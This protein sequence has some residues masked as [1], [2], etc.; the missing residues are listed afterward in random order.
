MSEPKA[1]LITGSTD[2][3]G[4]L[5]ARKL[6]ALGTTVLVHGRSRER[7]DQLVSQIRA[8]GGNAVFYQ[9]DLASLAQVRAL[10]DAVRRDHTRL[11]VLINNAGIGTG[12]RGAARQTSA[13]GYESRFAVNYLSGFLLTRLLLPLILRSAPARIVNV[14]SA[15]QYPL[16]F[17]NLMLT[18]A[19]SGMRAYAQSKLAQV[20]F[21][22]GLA[23]ELEGTG[24]TVN[25]LHPAT[26]MNTT[27]VHE[28]GVT[29]VSTVEEGAQ[30]VLRLAVAADLQNQTGAYF[31]GQRPGRAQAQAYDPQAQR[32]LHELSIEM[33][34]LVSP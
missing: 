14:A 4:R 24:V 27:M 8:D 2:G 15:G 6:A 32:R 16:D 30:A 17:D 11:D 34:G 25:C 7:G 10:A 31:D 13:D 12:G 26:Y 28:A 5:V 18:R 22:F 3:L 9:A 21:T 20:M 1:A 23:R 19:Y 33:T 29:P